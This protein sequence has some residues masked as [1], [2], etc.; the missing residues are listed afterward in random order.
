MFHRSTSL[1]AALIALGLFSVACGGGSNVSNAAPRVGEIPQQSVA[2]GT[3]FSIDLS[4][5]VT[6]REG[7]PL[8]YAVASGGGAFA[9]S[10]YSNTFDS[11]GTYT[12]QFTATDGSKTT[13]GSFDVRVTSAD[14]VVLREDTSGLLLVDAATDALVRVAASSS[15]PTFVAGLTD[16]RCV[17]QIGSGATLQLMVFDPMTR[18][19]TQVAPSKTHV[20]YRA[21]TTDG[22]LVY[23]TGPSTAM[24]LWVHNP[25]TGLTRQIT[26]GAINTLTV[27][28][29]AD[30]LV[31][32]EVEMSG[33]ADVWYYDPSAD[34]SYEVAVAASDEQLQATLAGGGVVLTRIGGGGE[35]DLFAFTRTTGLVEIGSDLSTTVQNQSKTYAGRTSDDKVVFEVTAAAS[36]DLYVWNLGTGSSRSIATG[37]NDERFAGVTATDGIV[38]R[39]VQS[40]SD[41]DLLHYDWNTDSIVTIRAT[42]DDESYLGSLSNGDVVVRSQSSG[43]GSIDLFL[44]D[45]SVPTLVTIASAGSDD[46]VFAAI[47]ADDHVVYLHDTGTPVLY[48]FDPAG[49]TSTA[50]ATG[51]SPAFGGETEG[52]DFTFTQTNS[53]QTDLYLWDASGAVAVPISTTTGDDAFAAWTATDKVLFTRVID[54]NTNRD[55]FVWNGTAETQLT[56]EGGAG[57]RHDHTAVGQYSGTRL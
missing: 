14:F 51:N 42:A 23:T 57:L 34:E 6:D 17:Y 7:S 33:Q 32:Y 11:M 1:P 16:G 53:A 15:A 46:Y 47:L 29:D 39:E 35:T 10:V 12:V 4:T 43:D 52:G 37:P 13:T 54:G 44:F 26:E 19:T 3:A 8:T 21:N 9:G 38:Y 27:L 5:Y 25:R 49:P 22:R 28:V 40:P 20:T 50:V 30:D 41:S 55:L 18:Q 48:V 31:F 45:V 2:G 24:T 56:D 36:S